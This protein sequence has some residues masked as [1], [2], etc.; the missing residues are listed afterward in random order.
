M[1]QI[2]TKEIGI[3][4]KLETSIEVLKANL[5]EIL[6]MCNTEV[7]IDELCSKLNILFRPI[8]LDG[9]SMLNLIGEKELS[10]EFAKQQSELLGALRPG[11]K[12]DIL[13]KDYISMD[14]LQASVQKYMELIKVEI[15]KLEG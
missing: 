14:N 5:A 9:I 8:F 12:E 3:L 6:L 10:G 7:T 13:L 11:T 2:H 4:D 15:E 1:Q